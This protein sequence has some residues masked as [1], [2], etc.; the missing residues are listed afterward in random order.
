[1]KGQ[2][3][4][5]QSLGAVDGPG[6]RFVIF[7][8]G[9]PLRCVYCHNPDTWD[10]KG[11][12]EYSVEQVVQKALKYKPYFAR[13]GGVTVS[14]GEPLLQWEFV[15]ELFK[16][17]HEHNIHTAL[18]TS[19]IADIDRAKEVLKN[20]D[21]VLCDLKFSNELDYVKYT[22]GSFAKVIEFLKLTE[23]MNIPL[24]IRH[25]VVPGLTDSEENILNIYNISKQFSNFKKLELLPFK[26]ICMSKYNAM[27][28]DFPLKEYDECSTLQI[29]KLKKLINII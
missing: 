15:S 25:V 10:I 16:L 21:L 11:G 14:G 7:M 13:S 8:Q 2:I 22:K 3:H 18:D 29:N 19:G 24:W 6:L 12:E 27:K 20:T 26:K 23:E 1:M 28:I 5:Y 4:S 9:C 17:L